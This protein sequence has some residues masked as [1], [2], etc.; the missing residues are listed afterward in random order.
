MFGE[1][2]LLKTYTGW[3]ADST[4]TSVDFVS[5]ETQHLLTAFKSNIAGII[6]IETGENIVKF[7]FGEGL[8][9]LFL[10]MN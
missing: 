4:P 1:S 7:D 3:V 8:T 10:F 6:D 9:S 5:T 2:P